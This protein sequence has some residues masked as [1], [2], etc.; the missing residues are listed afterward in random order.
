MLGVSVELFVDDMSFASHENSL[1]DKLKAQLNHEFE[2][3]DLGL[4][5]KVLGM[6]IQHD[7]HDDTLF[8]VS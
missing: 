7:R 1:I 4:V 2:M 5:K 8:F 6:K 3:K